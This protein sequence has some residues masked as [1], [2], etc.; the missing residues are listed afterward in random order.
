MTQR[1][2]R[3]LAW[4]LALAVAAPLPAQSLDP[5]RMRRME[6]AMVDRIA[7]Q[8]DLWFESGEFPRTVQTLRA[9]YEMYPSDYETATDLGWMLENIELWGEALATYVRFRHENADN[10]DASYPEANFYF[11]K[12][13]Y[14]E[15]PP[16]L[17]PSLKMDRPPHP[18]TYRVLAHSY[19]RLGLLADSKRVWELLVAL[20][21]DDDAAKVNLARVERKLKGEPPPK[22]GGDQPSEANG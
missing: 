9:R 11:L 21:P 5:G 16:L 13:L 3:A 10:P 1:Y 2:R 20:T 19:D 8:S 7:T 22:G 18:N 6:A 12:R 14:A 17:E 15:I 4:T